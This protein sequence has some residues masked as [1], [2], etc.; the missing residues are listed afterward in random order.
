METAAEVLEAYARWSAD[1]PDEMSTGVAFLNIPPLPA[2]PEPLRGRSVIALRGCYCGESP[3]A[4]EELLRPL[5]E[6][7]GEVI[8]DT[9]G[10]MPFA[11]MDSISMDPVDP[12]GARQ[13][14]EMLSDLSPEI[15]ETLVEVA[16]AGSESPLIVLELR[17]LGGALA[18]TAD[19]L[20]TMGAGDSRFIMNGVG[21]A[22]TPEMAEGVL[23][24][25]ARV[26]EATRPFQTGDTY[27]NFMELEGASP[28]RVKAAYA[29]ED[30][31]RL[32]AL[33]DRHDPDNLFRFNRNIA[34]SK[35]GH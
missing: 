17:Q 2:L 19:R 3:E 7:L 14:S 5:R 12:M 1:L 32:V 27:V 28:E 34:P 35:N 16:G 8:M 33:K 24:H 11:A 26:A 29:P 18:R 9:F 21:P 4:G 13:H 22:F 25:L 30:Y 20:S 31:E 23:A 15:I 6:E 10:P